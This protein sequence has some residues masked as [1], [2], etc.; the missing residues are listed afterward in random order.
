[1]R[2]STLDEL[3]GRLT[4]KSLNFPTSAQAALRVL[5]AINDPQCAIAGAAR[6]VQLEPML[7]AK[8]VAMSNTVAYNRSGRTVTSVQDALQLIGLQ[9]LK[10]LAVNVAMGRMSASTGA[11]QRPIATQL[12]DHSMQVGA[13]A[14]VLSRQ[15][16]SHLAD[17]AM[18][19]GTVHELSGFYLLTLWPDGA[20]GDIADIVTTLLHPRGAAAGAGQDPPTH[21]LAEQFARPLL[22]AMR[23][24]TPI[25]EAIQSTWYE[26]LSLPAETL[27]D[28]LMLADVLAPVRSPFEGT[29]LMGKP[30]DRL[31]LDRFVGKEELDAV[32]E[33][34]QETI[35]S[36]VGALRA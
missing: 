32:L 27:G 6:L 9:T 30:V 25:I 31:L 18:F 36:L 12:W 15:T 20:N 14:Y 34:S 1:M 11:A 19:A 26:D 3:V 8:A 2:D 13:I 21:P 29:L 4:E 7:A 28:T 33:E 23:I 17:A 16:M 22:N 5:D 35:K 10:M 24:P